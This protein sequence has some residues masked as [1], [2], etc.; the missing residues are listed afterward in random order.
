MAAHR[1]QQRSA[2]PAQSSLQSSSR[3]VFTLNELG[4]KTQVHPKAKKNQPDST[5]AA[6][7]SLFETVVGYPLRAVWLDL[8]KTAIIFILVCSLIG[9][10]SLSPLL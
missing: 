7:I 3:S 1:R 8:A 6:S 10:V 9:A 2:S 4:I 5:A